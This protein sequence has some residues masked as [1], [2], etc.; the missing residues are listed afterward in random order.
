MAPLT[1]APKAQK[2][3]LELV[4]LIR[5]HR[6]AHLLNR[7]PTLAAEEQ[8]PERVQK[9]LARTLEIQDYSLPAQ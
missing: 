2:T 9:R 8:L 4:R 5:K 3:S 7:C 1:H 6:R